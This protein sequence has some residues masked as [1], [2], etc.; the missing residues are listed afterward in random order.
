MQGFHP[1]PPLIK[2]YSVF[3][4]NE[5]QGGMGADATHR[6]ANAPQPGIPPRHPGFCASLISKVL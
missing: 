5:G 2:T 3:H 6:Y 1:Y 4:I